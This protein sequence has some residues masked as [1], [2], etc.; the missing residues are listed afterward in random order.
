MNTFRVTQWAQKSHTQSRGDYYSKMHYAVAEGKWLHSFCTFSVWFFWKLHILLISF[1]ILSPYSL[2]L[3]SCRRQLITAKL[4]SYPSTCAAQNLLNLTVKKAKNSKSA[5][6]RW[7][8]AGITYAV[9]SKI[10]A[11]HCKMH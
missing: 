7:T 10:G 11:A 8:S 6:L 2:S 3:R 4:S 1:F 5:C 9:W